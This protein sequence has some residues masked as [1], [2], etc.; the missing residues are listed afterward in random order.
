MSE[1]QSESTPDSATDPSEH[2]NGD[3]YYGRFNHRPGDE[4]G[5]EQTIPPQIDALI[6]KLAKLCAESMTAGETLDQG[7]LDETVKA[8]STNGWG[9]HSTN[10]PPLSTVVEVRT[11]EKYLEP[12][13]HR[14]GALENLC[15]RIQEAY[16]DG[17]RFEGSVP[18]SS[19]PPAD[20][21]STDARGPR[22]NLD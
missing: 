3:E 11:R 14:G 6:D 21:P 9:R 17:T 7:E 1:P 15:A 10:L 8:L 5:T 13:M 4:E 2:P 19:Q 22:T 12:A 20:D 18:Q 16:E